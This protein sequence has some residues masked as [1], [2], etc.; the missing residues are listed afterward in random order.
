MIAQ[1]GSRMAGASLS[2][3]ACARLVSPM[4]TMTLRRFAT[5]YPSKEN[6]PTKWVDA[7]KK[8]I[9]KP[10]TDSLLWHTPEGITVKVGWATRY[11]GQFFF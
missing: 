8:E 3:L 6:L 4:S 9:D 7:A 2:R 1:K 10:D 11:L 5:S